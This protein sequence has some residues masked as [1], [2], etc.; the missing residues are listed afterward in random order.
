MG[1]VKVD[2]TLNVHTQVLDAS[3]RSAAAR[4]GAR[5]RFSSGPDAAYQDSPFLDGTRLHG[6]INNLH[7]WARATAGQQQWRHVRGWTVV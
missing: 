1:H 2:T 6:T 7:E 4:V 3:V 5:G